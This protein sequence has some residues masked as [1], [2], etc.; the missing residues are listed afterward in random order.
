MQQNVSSLE[1]QLDAAQNKLDAATVISQPDVRNEEGLPLTEIYEE[2]DEDGNVICMSHKVSTLTQSDTAIASRL[3]QPGDSAPQILEVLKKAGVNAADV[4]AAEPSESNEPSV[5]TPS[6]MGSNLQDADDKPQTIMD[7]PEEPTTKLRVKSVSFLKSAKQ[8]ASEV[9]AVSAPPKTQSKSS[10]NK[11]SSI[12]AQG[13]FAG[14]QRVVEL[15]NEDNAISLSSS[16]PPIDESA[17]DAA[18]RRRMLEYN[19]NEMNHIVAQLDLEE[20]SQDSEDYDMA[21]DEDDFGS[22]TSHD[23]ENEYGMDLDRGISDKYKEEMV[24]LEKKLQAQML[25]NL[26]PRPE[27]SVAPLAKD[28]RRLVVQPD[29]PQPPPSKHS[30]EAISKAEQQKQKSVRFATELDVAPARA[31]TTTENLNPRETHANQRVS[32]GSAQAPAIK[33]TIIERQPHPPP[34]S[35]HPSATSKPSRFKSARTAPS[36][37]PPPT[38]H[39]SQLPPKPLTP[40]GPPNATLATTVVERPHRPASDSSPP[41][42]PDE[43]DP[44]IVRQQVA[45]EYYARRNR[46]IQRQGGFSRHAHR[47]EVEVS[48]DED[49]VEGGREKISLFKR[50]RLRRDAA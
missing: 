49:E 28:A 35:S 14:N 21:S 29:P 34:A 15:D 24:E 19:M 22:Q 6:R 17:E 26:G 13:P 46:E 50:A 36:A 3:S 1:K 47:D 41:A 5:A 9:Q 48:G 8:A 45:A 39:I 20:D 2:L 32:K 38:Q 27:D 43:F 40:T 44:A 33:D 12:R 25:Q 7:G 30:E 4:P 31:T 18:M 37:A 16:A 10:P 23:E 42:E 11:T